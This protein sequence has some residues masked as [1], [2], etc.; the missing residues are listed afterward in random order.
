MRG[1]RD[2]SMIRALCCGIVLTVS[3][4]AVA[5]T[6][7]YVA[8]MGSDKNSGTRPSAP[9]RKITTALNRAKAGTTVYLR[10]GTYSEIVATSVQGTPGHWVTLTNYPGEQPVLSGA[11]FYHPNDTSHDVL[12]T[13]N[14][15]SYVRVVGITVQDLESFTYDGALLFIHGG[16]DHVE[17]R[18][19]HFTHTIGTFGRAISVAADVP[20]PLTN[21]VIDSNLVEN[22]HAWNGEALT[23][24]GNVQGFEITSNEVKT[25]DSIAIDMKGGYDDGAGAGALNYVRQGLVQHNIV[26]DNIGDGT[27]HDPNDPNYTNIGAGAGIYVDGGRE[28]TID[29]NLVYN[30]DDGIDVGGEQVQGPSSEITISNNIVY[31]NGFDG[32]SV[33][34][35]PSHC[36][37]PTTCGTASHITVVDNTLVNNGT[38][39]LFGTPASLVLGVI[40][41]ATIQNNIVVASDSGSFIGDQT[42]GMQNQPDPHFSLDWNLYFSPTSAATADFHLYGNNYP[43]FAAFQSQTE[44]EQHGL[45]A[46]PLLADVGNSD[47]SLLAGSPAIDAANP[48]NYPATDYN[49]ITRPQ[50]AN[51]DIGALER[52]PDCMARK[53]RGHLS[54]PKN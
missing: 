52:V 37:T 34:V 47:F 29:S 14:S 53:R 10:G 9:L 25:A 18:D 1:I 42:Q 33:G 2:A 38:N 30:N 3:A 45:N 28:I 36:N 13:L 48:N 7:L 35:I 31:N 17:V 27:T 8:P 41:H 6:A 51:A 32:I 21:L 49:G 50:G 43:T 46:D 5:Q 11:A 12:L 22:T 4:G 23:L 16:G 44:R 54:R 40:T 20:T 19:C 39:G 15:P 26:H 24:T